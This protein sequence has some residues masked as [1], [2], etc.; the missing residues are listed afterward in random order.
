MLASMALRVAWHSPPV[1]F[2]LWRGRLLPTAFFLFVLGML[3]FRALPLAR[4]LPVAA[5]SAANEAVLAIVVTLPLFNL[6]DQ[7]GRWRVHGIVAAALPL[8]VTTFK[9][10]AAD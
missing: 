1:D 10:C 2:S 5:G 6:N 8:I 9:D 4:R 7:M 3:P